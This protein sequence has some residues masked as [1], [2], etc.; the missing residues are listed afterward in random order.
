MV[1]RVPQ[2]SGHTI[3]APHIEP[4]ARPFSVAFHAPASVNVLWYTALRA[5]LRERHQPPPARCRTRRLAVLEPRGRPGAP[6]R[7]KKEG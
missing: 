5:C 1:P 2:S 7:L 6:T 4:P 3:H